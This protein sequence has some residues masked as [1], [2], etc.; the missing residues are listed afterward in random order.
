MSVV[1][2]GGNECMVCKYKSLCKEYRCK[3]K[4][5]V[6]YNEAMKKKIGCPDLMVL[7]TSTVSHK[8]VRT[9]LSK[10]KGTDTV[11]VRSHSSSMAALRNI[12][13]QHA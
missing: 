3:A 6:N 5:F 1:I 7:F 11:I 9:A 8:M 2:I 10:P 4:V 12:M 13:E